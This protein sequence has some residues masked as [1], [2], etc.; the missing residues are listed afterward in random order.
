MKAEI[1][2]VGNELISGHIV[3]TNASRISRELLSLGIV[4]G[5]MTS[6]GDD[7]EAIKASLLQAMG[8]FPLVIV[9]G[10]LGPTVD[11][12]TA[13]AAAIALGRQ[14]ILNEEALEALRK[15]FEKF[16]RPLSPGNEK[17]ALLPE[18]AD[19]V[20]NPVGT[21][22]GF[23]II[24]G[25]ST[26]FFLPGVPREV[27]AMMKEG[28]LPYLKKAL[29]V[30]IVIR[31]R[32]VKVF[33]MSE[34][35]ID[36][37]MGPTIKEIESRG[38]EWASLPRYPEIHLKLTLKGTDS[39]HVEKAL[40]KACNLVEEKLADTVFGRDEDT[41]EEVVGNLLRERGVT[42]A[43]AESCTGG[44]IAHRL[45]NVPG[46]SDYLEWGV[47]VYS[48]RSKIDML[49]VPAEVIEKH[50]AV[51]EET[52]RAMAEG[53]RKLGKTT[54]GVGVTGIAGPTGGTEEKPVGTVFIALTDDDGTE[55]NRYFF[56]FFGSREQIKLFTSQVALNNLRKRILG[57]ETKVG[58]I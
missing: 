49:G 1:I 47:V 11:D 20:P 9:T 34:S 5:R 31:S 8:R 15:R 54:I 27:D 44:L 4:V 7:R 46:S 50:G 12:F 13:E 29:E 16:G 52:A 26:Y 56:G 18:E 19:V 2:T 22:C 33:G 3:D 28:V 48:N 21:A 39:A 45:T 43:V 40:E 23:R 10:G 57:I 30:K 51:S 58:L 35:G 53:V 41:M 55:A 17:Q 36:E 42:L 24:Q 32:M 38:I 25:E 6:V 37:M 14:L